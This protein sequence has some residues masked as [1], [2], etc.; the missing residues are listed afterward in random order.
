MIDDQDSETLVQEWMSPAV[1][2]VSCD[3]TV[4]DA[5]AKLGEHQVSALPVLDGQGHF[6]GLVTIADFLRALMATGQ[7]L[8]ADYPH[9]DDCLW[10][11]ELIQRKLGTD[12]IRSVMTEVIE[13]VTP[14]DSMCKAARTM[15]RLGLH[16]L[17]VVWNDG[18]LAGILS[19]MDFVRLLAS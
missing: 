11:V 12:T 9:Y 15:F 5:L 10:A 7:A 4:R 17:P 1:I 8:D 19:S 16:H 13:T 6:V 18:K 14:E 3:Q 2:T